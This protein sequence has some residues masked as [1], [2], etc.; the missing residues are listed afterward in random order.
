MALCNCAILNK[1]KNKL[2]IID[3]FFKTMITNSVR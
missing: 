1:E 2:Q 3:I